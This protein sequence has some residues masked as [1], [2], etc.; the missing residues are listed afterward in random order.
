MIQSRKVTNCSGKTAFCTAHVLNQRVRLKR[1]HTGVSYGS[2]A[3]MAA[4]TVC[5][6]CD[7]ILPDNSDTCVACPF[8][9]SMLSSA[10]EATTQSSL[11]FQE[12]SLILLVWPP[13]MNSS[14]GGPS[15]ASS[16]DCG[17]HVTGLRAG[18]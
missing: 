10:T 6:S 2:S 11:A 12:K 5:M 7:D 15:S 8:T 3:S 16:E 4:L 14:S 1:G 18:F 17:S 13:W 9:C